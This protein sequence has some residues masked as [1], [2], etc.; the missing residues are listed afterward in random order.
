MSWRAP[1]K[2][3]YFIYVQF[4]Y[5]YIQSTFAGLLLATGLRLF[6]THNFLNRLFST[7]NFETIF[8][9]QHPKF[10]NPNKGTE[11]V[12]WDVTKWQGIKLLLILGL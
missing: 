4:I 6:S 5:N 9:N 1:E 12:L 11:Y 8:Y 7:R 2:W 10:Q 3:N